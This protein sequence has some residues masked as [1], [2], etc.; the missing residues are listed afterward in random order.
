[1]PRPVG[2]IAGKKHKGIVADEPAFG[3]YEPDKSW[4]AMMSIE[5]ELAANAMRAKALELEEAGWRPRFLFAPDAR[6]G[7]VEG[8]TWRPNYILVLNTGEA[9][10]VDTK[11]DLWEA[12]ER[13]SGYLLGQIDLESIPKAYHYRGGILIAVADLVLS[14]RSPDEGAPTGSL[15]SLRAWMRKGCP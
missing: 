12:N 13:F 11:E 7:Y 15:E 1:M 3:Q 2:K 6:L 4:V 5:D 8:R 10:G 14:P 9:I